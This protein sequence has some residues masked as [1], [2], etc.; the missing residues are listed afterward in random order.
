MRSE[1]KLEASVYTSATPQLLVWV[2][3]NR[4]I[5]W[6]GGQRKME[7]KTIKTTLGAIINLGPPKK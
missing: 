6:V 1:L 5:S 7:G 3:C 2:H 4:N